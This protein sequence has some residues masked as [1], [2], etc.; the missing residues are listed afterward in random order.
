[1]EGGV[2]ELHDGTVAW[3]QIPSAGRGACFIVRCKTLTLPTWRKLVKPESLPM[4]CEAEGWPAL[5][6]EYDAEE[7]FWIDHLAMVIDISESRLETIEQSRESLTA[8]AA[9]TLSIP[10]DVST[11]RAFI[12]NEFR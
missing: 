3:L 6:A 1:M 7:G 11:L 12:A 8:P 2:R 10:A 4:A 9:V 5:P